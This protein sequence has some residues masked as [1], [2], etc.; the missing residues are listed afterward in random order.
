[1]GHVAH[2]VGCEDREG[3]HQ[4][5]S[6]GGQTLHFIPRAGYRVGAL[7]PQ[8][9]ASWEFRVDPGARG[10]MQSNASCMHVCVLGREMS[11]INKWF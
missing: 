8:I 6:V 3:P 4:S 9:T 11:V 2:R 5:S 1:M 7:T 10:A